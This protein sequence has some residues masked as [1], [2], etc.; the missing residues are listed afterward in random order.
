MDWFLLITFL[1]R[2]SSS[3]QINLYTWEPT[4]AR[5][6][7]FCEVL[8]NLSAHHNVLNPF[9]SCSYCMGKWADQSSPENVVLV[10]SVFPWACTEGFPSFKRVFLDSGPST[11]WLAPW[12]AFRV[13]A[14]VLPRCFEWEAKGNV[15]S[16]FRLGDSILLWK[17]Q[18]MVPL[19]LWWWDVLS[20]WTLGW[21]TIL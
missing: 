11:C 14:L 19:F 15:E 6:F 8:W 1:C 21:K 4:S 3:Q 20:A 9:Y 10:A 18:N 5:C 2:P 16:R 12:A 13:V 17:H 7:F